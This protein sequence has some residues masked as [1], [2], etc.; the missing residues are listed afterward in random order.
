MKYVE[1]ASGVTAAVGPQVVAV[2]V[3]DRPSTCRKVRDRL[4]PGVVM[5]ALEAGQPEQYA[6]AADV[7]SLL[8]RLRTAA[9]EP[10]PAVGEGQEYR[11]DPVPSAHASA[12]A[13][14]GSVLHGSA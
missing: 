14:G 12:L 4:L 8:S 3:F 13:L 11:P 5:D 1:G 7:Q 6:A 9:W 2:D 10:P